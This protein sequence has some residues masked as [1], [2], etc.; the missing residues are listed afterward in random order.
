MIN[1][2]IKEEKAQLTKEKLKNTNRFSKPNKI[3]CRR[4][5]SSF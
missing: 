3:N 1:F 4:C 2:K 5:K